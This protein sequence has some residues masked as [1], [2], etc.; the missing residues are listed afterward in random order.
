MADTLKFKTKSDITVLRSF[1]SKIKYDPQ[2][3]ALVAGIIII[4]LRRFDGTVMDCLEGT[5]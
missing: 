5:F 4:L 2:F 3:G 1:T